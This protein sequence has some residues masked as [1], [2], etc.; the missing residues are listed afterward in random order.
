MLKPKNKTL[1]LKNINQD[2]ILWEGENLSCI[3]VYKG[4]TLT[5]TVHELATLV[6]KQYDAVKN[7]KSL[8][9]FCLDK[10][11]VN[12]LED[13]VIKD[14]IQMLLDNDCKIKRLITDYQD[15]L[16]NTENLLKGL[17]LKCLLESY[18]LTNPE[19]NKCELDLDINKVLAEIIPFL[20]NLLVEY[21]DLSD[22]Y[23][24]IKVAFDAFIDE[25]N[26]YTEP[27]INSC[28]TVGD[29]LI[30]SQHVI[31]RTDAEICS[32]QDSVGDI[33][34]YINNFCNVC[35][36]DIYNIGP[37]EYYIN[38]GT[39]TTAF[40][41]L[42]EIEYDGITYT[43]LYNVP[44]INIKTDSELEFLLNKILEDNALVG[45]FYVIDGE[46]FFSGATVTIDITYHDCIAVTDTT[47]TMTLLDVVGPTSLAQAIDF[48]K[49]LICS[50]K[51]RIEKIEN[52]CCKVNCDDIEVG[53]N[54]T[55]DDETNTYTLD[56][57]KAAGTNIPEG[58]TDCGS[59]ITLVDHNG[60]TLVL[61]I[62]IENDSTFEVD[63]S[64]LDNTQAISVGIKTCL[65]YLDNTTCRKCFGGV[66]NPID[67]CGFCKL[68]VTGDDTSGYATIIYT[69][70]TGGLEQTAKV[71]VG[72][73]LTFELPDEEPTIINI[74]VSSDDV[75]VITDEEH[76]CF[77]TII[78]PPIV[79]TCWFFEIPIPRTH[80]IVLDH[81]LP[82][83]V[84]DTI[85]VIF[86]ISPKYDFVDIYSM[87]RDYMNQTTLPGSLSDYTV[88]IPSLTDNTVVNIFPNLPNGLPTNIV[89]ATL[90]GGINTMS[91]DDY[92][93]LGAG[94]IHA[95]G[96]IS[97][98][99]LDLTTVETMSANSFG[100]ILTISGQP[101]TKYAPKPEIAIYNAINGATTWIKG[102]YLSD[103]NCPS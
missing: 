39:Q 21:T 48:Q 74:T 70:G 9:L 89:S 31:N 30:L 40:C 63:V 65:T 60:K 86:K 6:C 91:I 52:T 41:E 34:S 25:Y 3:N 53:F 26:I 72:Q 7:L 88:S 49:K 32:L 96:G 46:I 29:P 24:A 71:N 101:L 11:C 92:Q 20:C 2:C 43:N 15:A 36:D 98:N 95:V 77:N 54:Q 102:Q 42:L 10:S 37:F 84:L 55:Y 57:I 51:R 85:D 4:D 62:V 67:K 97:P 87:Y 8:N 78:P 16:D 1:S 22:R 90:C 61:D 94:Q 33:D 12:C 80:D 47:V 82:T 79:D 58:F 17:D 66:L 64:T 45:V 73:C 103:C 81:T 99:S 13:K 59:E 83:A 56:F 68:C 44:G 76:P 50:L 75:Q 69:T 27:E 35:T 5:T 18:L 38:C 23:D 28:L 19:A 14:Y 100:F 93:G